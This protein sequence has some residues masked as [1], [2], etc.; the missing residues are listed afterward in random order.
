LVAATF[1]CDNYQ[2]QISFLTIKHHNCSVVKHLEFTR[3]LQQQP[4]SF[5]LQ[6][7]YTVARYGT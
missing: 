7:Q 3:K 2:I 4:Q 5:N 1:H 6:V